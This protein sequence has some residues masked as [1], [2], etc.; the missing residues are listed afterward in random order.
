MRDQLL[1]H[2]PPE[3]VLELHALDEE[4]MLRIEL[5]RGHR[6]LEVEAQP[7][8]NASEASALGEV[9]EQRKVEHDRRREDRVTAEEVHLDLHRIA[10]PSADIDVVPPLLRVATGWIVVDRDLVIHVSV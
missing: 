7:F 6:A 4:I 3:R 9:H 2:H 5:L 10:E 8:L 1:S